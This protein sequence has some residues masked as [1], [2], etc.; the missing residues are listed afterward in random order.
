[1]NRGVSPMHSRNNRRADE[2]DD[3]AA[4]SDFIRNNEMFEVDERSHNQAAQ[5]NAIDQHQAWRLPPIS[6]PQSEKQQ[7]GE[8]FHKKVADR[9]G[10]FA[11]GA[12]APQI[13]PGKER[14]VEI[15]G[16]RILAV[17]TV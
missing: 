16:N 2:T 11:I 1:M 4:K 7:P 6:E 10:R 5:E 3:D 12:F 9:D 15:P 14:D 17:W 13:N 8:Q